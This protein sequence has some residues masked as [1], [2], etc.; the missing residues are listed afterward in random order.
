MNAAARIR[1]YRQ[2][3]GAAYTLHR[4]AQI[5]R[6]RWGGAY[7]R[8]R[9]QEQPSEAELERQRREQPEAG[10]ISVV[11]PVY[12]TDPRMLEELLSCLRQQTY[13]NVEVLLYDGNS[14][15]AETRAVLKA[16]EAD[17]F[18][19]VYG[20]EN[21]GIS[22][23]TNAALL[24]AR[25]DYIALVDHDDLI[26]PDAL[27]RMAERIALD[28]PD[29][30]YSDEDRI[31]EGG[32]H[33][34]DPHYKPDFCPETLVSDNYICH[35]AVIR[36]SLLMDIGGLRGGFDG[37]QDH[38]L[39][40]R[41]SEK[42]RRFAHVPY[43]LYSWREVA[44]SRSHLDLQTCLESSCRAVEEHEAKAGRKVTALPVNKAL[45]LWYEV[46]AEATLEV[47]IHGE[48]EEA[49]QKCLC[50]VLTR[51]GWRHMNA[52]LIIANEPGRFA[53]INE[54][55]RGSA[56]DYLLVLEAGVYG[57]NRHFIRELM[58]YAREEIA[59]V[60]PVL[61][62]QKGRITHGGFV[63]GRTDILAC[64]VNEGLKMG[65]G[66]WHDT[67]NKVHNVAAVSP[68]CMLVK[69]NCWMDFDENYRSGLAGADL[70][71]R[72]QAAGRRFVVTPHA[73]AVRE[74]CGLLLSGRD[75]DPRDAVLYQETWG[76]TQDPCYS[77]RFD[78]DN[79][80]YRY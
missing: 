21:R 55:A 40:L 71:L 73:T 61:T 46:D 25:G 67:M 70:G 8:R 48:S 31:M 50:E 44:S 74:K 72:Q 43:T 52:A 6:E 57:M 22:G 23:N 3:H 65:A 77:S 66:G 60:A 9:R 68:C 29:V 49:C 4:C 64:T 35:L 15:R 32:L 33:H 41:L 47:L 28:A 54:A 76:E 38:D 39:F 26:T 37:S 11:A 58:M 30:L 51:T 42:T 62:D 5:L 59:G 18:R 27:W 79:G 34:M 16:A 7:D 36:K 63:L 10:L 20:K 56:A 80:N 17:G 12:N 53:A 45:R 14:T 69:K 24:A 2:T 75:R 1:E 13:R 78:K 19:V